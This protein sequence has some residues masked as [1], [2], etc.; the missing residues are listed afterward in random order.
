MRALP[1]FTVAGQWRILTAFPFIRQR[2]R[3]LRI[4]QPEGD[5]PPTLGGRSRRNASPSSENDSK[6]KLWQS[7]RYGEKTHRA[8]PRSRTELGFLAGLLADALR[9]ERLPI[10]PFTYRQTV[11]IVF[12]PTQSQWRGRAGFSPAS[13]C[14]EQRVQNNA[15]NG[16]DDEPIDEPC[17]GLSRT[18]WCWWGFTPRDKRPTCSP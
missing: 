18:V 14:S 17:Q 8:S 5:T 1:S 16:G 4:S 12:R 7:Q 3:W 13:L 11:A 9:S 2:Y 10:H 6:E 15:K